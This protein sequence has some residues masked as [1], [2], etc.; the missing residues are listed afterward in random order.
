MPSRAVE[1][2]VITAPWQTCAEPG[3]AL[4]Q[5]IIDACFSQDNTS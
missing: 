4:G 1:E 2:A 5:A 3:G